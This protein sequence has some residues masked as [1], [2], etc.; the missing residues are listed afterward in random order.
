MTEIRAL[1]SG[2]SQSE[3]PHPMTYSI[4]HARGS[5]KDA[6]ASFTQDTFEWGDYVTDQFDRWLEDPNGH[7]IVGVDENDT[8]V[9]I[10]FAALL[11]LWWIPDA[12]FGKG[13]KVLMVL[14]ILSLFG[15]LAWLLL[16]VPAR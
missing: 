13:P 1:G 5:D 6:I 12:S 10:S 11:S 9:A 3:Y 8:A 4:R 2:L 16:F 14:F 15:F 7:L